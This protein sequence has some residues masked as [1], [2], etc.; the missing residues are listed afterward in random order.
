MVS[1]CQLVMLNFQALFQLQASHLFSVSASRIILKNYEAY[2][3]TLRADVVNHW[4]K[5]RNLQILTLNFVDI[6]L[7]QSGRRALNIRKKRIICNQGMHD[8]LLCLFSTNEIIALHSFNSVVVLERL[9]PLSHHFAFIPSSLVT[10]LASRLFVIFIF[11][12][13]IKGRGWSWYFTASRLLL[14]CLLW[15]FTIYLCIFVHLFAFSN[16]THRFHA[17]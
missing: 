2:L 8:Y 7:V 1:V 6:A 4:I 13:S 16:I 15:S 11:T 14:R 3:W 9:G 10:H 12:M 5:Q 17:V